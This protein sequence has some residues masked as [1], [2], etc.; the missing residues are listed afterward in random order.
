[1]SRLLNRGDLK[2]DAMSIQMENFNYL[3]LYN[4]NVPANLLNDQV[5]KR[6]SFE[7]VAELLT[8]DFESK[9]VE[10][11]ITASYILKH[12]ET[13]A[14]RFWSGSFFAKEDS[15]AVLLDFQKFDRRNFVD[16][17]LAA[18]QNVND[19]LRW[20][21]RETVWA[22]SQLESLI[23]NAESKVRANSKIFD[24]RGIVKRLKKNRVTFALE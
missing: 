22:F 4:I 9:D 17:A 24:K 7:R 11:Q 3:I 21:G 5:Q 6:A 10:Y 12:K 23:F 1:M 19:K 18:T 20:R 14:E 8:T 16:I 2:V 13:G 15:P